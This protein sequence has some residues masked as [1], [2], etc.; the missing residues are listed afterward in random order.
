MLKIIERVFN[1]TFRFLQ[2]I[3]NYLYNLI[4]NVVVN[5]T[6]NQPELNTPIQPLSLVSDDLPKLE[7]KEGKTDEKIDKKEGQPELWVS[8][9]MKKDPEKSPGYIFNY[10]VNNT[11][12]TS[13]GL[14]LIGEKGNTDLVLLIYSFLKFHDQKNAFTLF[15][16]IDGGYFSG[17]R[18]KCSKFVFMTY[19]KERV[20][21]RDK[22]NDKY[23]I[24]S[25]RF[26]YIEGASFMTNYI[27][28]MIYE[29]NL[30]LARQELDDLYYESEIMHKDYLE[31]FQI[32]LAFFNKKITNKK[33]I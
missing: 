24:I 16:S 5:N 8:L 23:K 12:M 17:A 21:L 26:E 18:N 31:Y 22:T 14:L 25:K 3:G 4:F 7:V 9:R 19:E 33:A 20:A 15:N 11:E 10:I 2:Y 28:H 30:N 6:R 29:A 27:I 13:L 1:A 32:D